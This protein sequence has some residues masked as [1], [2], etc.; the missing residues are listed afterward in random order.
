[1]RAHRGLIGIDSSFPVKD[2]M[3]YELLGLCG[4]GEGDRMVRDGETELG[5]RIPFSTDG[6]LIGRGHPDGPAGLAQVSETTLQ[7]RGQGGA[8]QVEGAKVGMCHMVSG[9]KR[10]HHSYPPAG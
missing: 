5:G 8:R 10:V 6:G 4:A 1:L 7:L 2:L 9:G 3:Y